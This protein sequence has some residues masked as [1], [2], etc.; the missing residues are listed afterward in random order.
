MWYIFKHAKKAIFELNLFHKIALAHIIHNKE[1][2]F[3]RTVL[4]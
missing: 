3:T 4:N 1:S 2:F